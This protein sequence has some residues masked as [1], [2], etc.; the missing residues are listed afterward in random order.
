MAL[1]AIL[2]PTEVSLMEVTQDIDWPQITRQAPG[3][4]APKR[5]V[6]VCVRVRA[7]LGVEE[8]EEAKAHEANGSPLHVSRHVS[9][10][11]RLLPPSLLRSVP[12]A[13]RFPGRRRLSRQRGWAFSTAG[14]AAAR[15]ARAEA[16]LPRLRP[17]R[18][19]GSAAPLPSG[20]CFPAASSATFPR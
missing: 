18:G 2:A 14:G 9:G 20:G 8:R 1:G 3:G 10:E 5:R 12:I 16:F 19:A 11:M 4:K 17:G 15:V 13:P 7:S 6:G